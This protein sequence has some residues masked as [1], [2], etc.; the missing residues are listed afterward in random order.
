VILVLAYYECPMLCTLVLNGMTK[1]LKTISFDTGKEYEV[2]VISID[3]GETPALA[4]EKKRNYVMSYGRTQAAAGW[5]FLTGKQEDITR[6]ADA[7]GYRYRY[8]EK[9]DEYVHAAGLVIATPEGKL[10]R[11]FFGV[12]FAPRD[13]R[14]G[15]VE[16]SDNE[17]GT[18]VDSVLLLCFHYDPAL[19]KYGFVVSNALRI[20]GFATVLLLGLFVARSLLKERRAQREGEA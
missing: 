16:A 9:R 7:A 3:P 12:E 19:G 17:I 6:A 10:S 13:L 20:G 2:V 14:L 5:H 11:Y 1:S 8:D 18:L 4:A 15:L